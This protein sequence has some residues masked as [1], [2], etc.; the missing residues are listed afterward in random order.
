[1]TRGQ[2]YEPLWSPDG[3]RLIFTSERDGNREIY[4]MGVNGRNVAN[5]TKNKAQ[6]Y[7][8]SWSPDGNYIAFVSD[9]DDDRD[10]EIYVMDVDGKNPVNVTKSDEPDRGPKWQP[11]L[12]KGVTASI[13]TAAPTTIAVGPTPSPTVDAIGTRIAGYC[14]DGNRQIVTLPSGLKYEDLVICE[15]A[16]A[17]KSGM[18]VQIH[19][20]GTLSNGKKFDSSY[21]RGQPFSFVLGAGQVIKGL[22]EGLIGMKVG[23]KRRLTIPPELAYGDRSL[24]GI[25][26]RST[27]IFEV[28]LLSAK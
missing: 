27:L 26:L 22:D 1:L 16:T 21:D 5:L 4:G 7:E 24:P 2:D 17:A 23:G 3:K 14:V 20:V 13:R 12:Q 10:T 25:P 28:E 15:Q 19:Y 18:T 11:I 6:D 8:P 9:R